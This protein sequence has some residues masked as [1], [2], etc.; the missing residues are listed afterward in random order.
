MRDHEIGELKADPV[1]GDTPASAAK[2]LYAY[3][4]LRLKFVPPGP[5]SFHRL[6]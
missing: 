1:K 3:G 5:S 2:Y 6:S 4:K